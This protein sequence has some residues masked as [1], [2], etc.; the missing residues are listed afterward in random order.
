MSELI[1]LLF[2]LWEC[3]EDTCEVNKIYRYMFLTTGQ[4]NE[5]FMTSYLSDGFYEIHSARFFS[6]CEL[7]KTS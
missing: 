3:D 4:Y 1:Y 7:I 2:Y 6:V 5:Y